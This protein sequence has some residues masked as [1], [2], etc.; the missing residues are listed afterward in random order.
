MGVP[1]QG[2]THTYEVKPGFLHSP[3]WTGEIAVSERVRPMWEKHLMGHPSLV[4][5]VCPWSSYIWLLDGQ[6]LVY[7][8]CFYDSSFLF[9]SCQRD[10]MIIP[11]EYSNCALPE[12]D[13]RVVQRYNITMWHFDMATSRYQWQLRSIGPC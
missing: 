11:F 10:T 5:L 8:V 4:V 12:Y 3:F 13:V 7:L 1:V 2:H 6:F 9:L